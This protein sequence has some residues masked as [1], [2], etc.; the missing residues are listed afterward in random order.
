MV[1]GL[2]PKFWVLSALELRSRYVM[3]EISPVRDCLEEET[4]LLL[5]YPKVKE[6]PFGL[7]IFH[8]TI[9][10]PSYMTFAIGCDGPAPQRPNLDFS[11]RAHR[12]E[13][14]TTQEGW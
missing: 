9:A 13:S 6:S 7:P 3:R 1:S 11:G 14:H 10:V 5:D 4:L 12:E 2:V 8:F